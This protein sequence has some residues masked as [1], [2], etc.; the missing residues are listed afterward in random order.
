VLR[1]TCV[2]IASLLSGC[3]GGSQDDGHASYATFASS[4]SSSDTGID[5]STQ[6]D[7]DDSSSTA[8]STSTDDGTED[9]GTL[10]AC[11]GACVDLD[12]DLENCGGCSITCAIPNAQAQCVSGQCDLSQCNE[13]WTNCDGQLATGCESESSCVPG[14]SCETVCGSVGETTC[15][16]CE[17]VCQTM[18]ETCNAMDDDCNGQ[19]DEGPLPGCRVGVHR[20]NGGALGHLYTLDLAEAQSGGFNL[21]SMNF[22]HVYV[23]EIDGLAPLHRCLKPNGK[24]LYTTA[25][26]CEGGGQLESILGYIAPDARCGA[27]PLYRV[28]NAASDAHFYTTSAAERDN[29][30]TNLGYSDEGITGYVWASL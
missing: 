4:A 17:P 2:A 3:G 21:E 25:A 24:R 7:D 27:Q 22:F 29:A 12:T 18:A 1:G 13:G 20:A 23:P 28:Y 8:V 10:V 9:C 14:T 5:E 30:V 26:N 6:G 19:C 11:E 16:A 15:N